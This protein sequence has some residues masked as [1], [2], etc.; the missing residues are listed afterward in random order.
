MPI[1]HPPPLTPILHQNTQITQPN[2]P[3]RK[4][5]P[6]VLTPIPMPYAELLPHLIRNS[7]VTTIPLKPIQPPY[8]KSYDPNAKCE[9]HAGVVGHVTAKCWGLKHKVQDLIDMGWLSF[10]ENNLNV[11]NNPLLEH[12]GSSINVVM[13]KGDYMIVRPESMKARKY[14]SCL[15]DAEFRELLQELMD[16][17][18]VQV[19]KLGR[20][21][22]IA[23]AH[24]E[25][26]RGT[27]RPLII[28]F[29]PLTNVSKPLEIR[30]PTP[31]L[32]KDSKVVP[33]K[34]DAEIQ[35]RAPA[36]T[37]ITGTRGVTQSGCV[38]ALE[39]LQKENPIKEKGEEVPLETR[40][41]KEKAI[42]EEEKGK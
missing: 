9:Y 6:K 18:F 35:S 34:Y 13:G 17:K 36:V 3:W 12:H 42:E 14:G 5:N 27:P 25:N 33:W 38:S 41:K 7:L 39:N 37:R 28:H 4:N 26:R 40:K 1:Y 23:T 22:E 11:D 24:E 19:D 16:A 21:E 32:Y 2:V 31:F 10:K 8:L 20:N 30:V 29:T 15:D